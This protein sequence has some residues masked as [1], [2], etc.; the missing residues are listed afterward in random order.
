[1]YRPSSAEDGF[2]LKRIIIF[3][4]GELPD[5]VKARAL[6]QPGDTVIC[7]DGGTRHALA[8]GTRPDLIIGD[9]DSAE[10]ETVR[11]FKNAGVEIEIFP[12]IRMKRIS[13][14]P[15]TARLR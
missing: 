9:L 8:L 1:M 2:L 5:L 6:I 13:S 11:K 15:S 12:G 10:S 14:W 4:N 3:A 7:A